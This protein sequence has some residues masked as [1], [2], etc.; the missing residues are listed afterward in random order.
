MQDTLS[1]PIRF[2]TKNGTDTK[3]QNKT[4]KK[5]PITSIP[6]MFKENK[7]KVI[8]CQDNDAH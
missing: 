1:T 5:N 7:N 8:S 6:K 4:H 3:K 2:D